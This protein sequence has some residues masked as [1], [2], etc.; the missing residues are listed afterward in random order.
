MVEKVML[1]G[2]QS[3]ERPEVQIACLSLHDY[4][5]KLPRWL[6]LENNDF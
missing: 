5:S 3:Y 6:F 2:M 1:T 4:T